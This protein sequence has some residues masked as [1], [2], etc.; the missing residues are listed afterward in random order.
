MT[1]SLVL[2]KVEPRDDMRQV[3][4]WVETWQKSNWPVYYCLDTGLYGQGMTATGAL[5]CATEYDKCVHPGD[6]P[7]TTEHDCRISDADLDGAYPFIRTDKR[8]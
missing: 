7:D 3:A 8:F 1:E 6:W 4:G 5:W 2:M